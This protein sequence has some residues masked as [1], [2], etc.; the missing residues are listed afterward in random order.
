MRDMPLPKSLHCLGG[1]ALPPDMVPDLARFEALPSSAREALWE[2][3]APCLAETLPASIEG[4]LDRFCATHRAD[5]NEVAAVIKALRF[6]LR[7]AALRDLS[8]AVFAEDLASV[9]G[10]DSEVFARM[11]PRYEA[12]KRVVRDEVLRRSLT[13]HGALLDGTS[14]RVDYLVSSSHG[15]KLNV[16]V[17]LLTLAYTEG[18]RRERLTLQVLPEQLR[19]LR[20]ICDKLL[21]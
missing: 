17:T 15:D 2:A 21:A 11:L 8:R 1:A 19:A 18:T 9:A 16:P 5:T 4:D 6:L 12:A 10:A 13:D 14:Y 7:E 20:A 3:L